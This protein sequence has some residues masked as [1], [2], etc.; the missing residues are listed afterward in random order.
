VRQ[1]QPSCPWGE[2]ARE[3]RPRPRLPHSRGFCDHGKL[4]RGQKVLTKGASGGVGTSAVQPAK[5]LGAEVT[6][7]CSTKNVDL[8]QSIGADHVMDYTN[9]D[10]KEKP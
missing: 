10:F 8:V 6:G 4:Q 3:H 1:T 7:V 5:A 2:V 9:E